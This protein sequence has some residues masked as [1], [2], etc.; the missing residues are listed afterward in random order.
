MPRRTPLPA[1]T[2]LR[3]SARLTPSIASSTVSSRESTPAM[4]RGAYSMDHDYI[5]TPQTVKVGRSRKEPDLPEYSP[6]KTIRTPRSAV[7]SRG[8]AKKSP[9]KSTYSASS[10]SM[11]YMYGLDDDDDI[12]V[13]DSVS[14][15]GSF[16]QNVSEKA[17]E[18]TLDESGI[19]GDTEENQKKGFFPLLVSVLFRVPVL[20]AGLIVT[21]ILKVFNSLCKLNLFVDTFF[22][23]SLANTFR[24]FANL[25]VRAGRVLS[26][27]LRTLFSELYFRLSLF[28]KKF[29]IL[30]SKLAIGVCVLA[31]FGVGFFFAPSSL[32]N[33]PFLLRS[34]DRMAAW[35]STGMS[36]SSESFSPE[37]IKQVLTGIVKDDSLKTK[38]K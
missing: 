25:P 8:S 19:V 20:I 31:I 12:D 35:A 13:D 32:S 14:N 21:S 15:A 30:H 7:S 26:Y 10:R 29:V 9:R 23:T 24:F 28:F 11:S 36:F 3:R 22:L 17:I 38:K 16:F 33:S 6:A 1:G 34:Q 27:G 2:P 18:Q 5:A 4:S 37:A